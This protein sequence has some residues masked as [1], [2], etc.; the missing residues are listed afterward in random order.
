M[1]IGIKIYSLIILL[2]FTFFSCKNSEEKVPPSSDDATVKSKDS[3]AV[4]VEEPMRVFP[5]EVFD[6]FDDDSRLM[7]EYKDT[8]N[9]LW[10]N[11]TTKGINLEHK[12]GNF[13]FRTGNFYQKDVNNLLVGFTN[14]NRAIRFLIFEIGVSDI[15]KKFEYRFP[16]NV[17]LREH[18][19]ILEYIRFEDMDGSLDNDILVPYDLNGNN[20]Y[21]SLFLNNGNGSFFAI[22]VFQVYPNASYDPDRK[23]IYS[24]YL[25]GCGNSNWNLKELKWSGDSLKLVKE[26][27][28]T[29]LLPDKIKITENTVRDGNTTK[30]ETYLNSEEEVDEVLQKYI[31]Y[32]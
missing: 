2:L 28:R 19:T 10:T 23:L 25:E 20:K 14:D 30:K 27:N 24:M 29:F 13:Y 3:V 5:V 11:F 12:I 21:Y 32:L 17:S 26:L 7:I 31:R 9:E 15:I 8:L 16:E 18:W 1:L 22:P 6:K 4:S